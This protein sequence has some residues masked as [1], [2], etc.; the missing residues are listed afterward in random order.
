[1]ATKPIKPAKP[2]L[3]QVKASLSLH[4]IAIRKQDGEYRVNF[5]LGG[6]ETTA[7]YTNDIEDALKTGLAM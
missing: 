5:I 7:Y 4:G 6:N 2:T 3:S 1:M